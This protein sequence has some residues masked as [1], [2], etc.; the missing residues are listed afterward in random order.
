M[1]KYLI[2]CLKQL[3]GKHGIISEVRGIGLM[4]GIQ[5][6]EERAPELKNELLSKGI[7][8]G[9][10]GLDTIR[11]LPPLIVTKENIDDFIAV[12]DEVLTYF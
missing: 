5:L 12:L 4:I 8:V 7:L 9:S 3:A 10:V 11:M 1:G 2:D 6:H